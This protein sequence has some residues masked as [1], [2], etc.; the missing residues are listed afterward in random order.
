M[1]IETDVI[2]RVYPE[3]GEGGA[4]LEVGPCADAPDYVELRTVGKASVDWFG[5]INLSMS[6]DLAQAL[7]AALIHAATDGSSAGEGR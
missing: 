1:K 2:R 7:G 4:C 6:K 3:H 5:A